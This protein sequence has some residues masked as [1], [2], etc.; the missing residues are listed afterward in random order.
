MKVQ[1]IKTTIRKIRAF[2][3]LFL[4]ESNFQFIYNKC[5]AYGQANKKL[6]CMPNIFIFYTM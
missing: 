5:H 1:A 4:Q 6:G 3:S 2:H